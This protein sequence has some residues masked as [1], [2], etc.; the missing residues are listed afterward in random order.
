M[1]SKYSSVIPKGFTPSRIILLGEKVSGETD[2]YMNIRVNGGTDFDRV[3]EKY[4]HG[5]KLGSNYLYLDM[6]VDMLG[7]KEAFN[8]LDPWTPA[9]QPRSSRRGEV[10]N[11]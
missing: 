4:R 9:S 2:C 7:P 8:G 10:R 11:A 6:H 1:A 5:I 3:V